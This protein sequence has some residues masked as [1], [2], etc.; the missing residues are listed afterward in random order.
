MRL[1]PVSLQ[2]CNSHLTLGPQ[3]S[4][5]QCHAPVRQNE[6]VLNAH[7]KAFQVQYVP[8]EAPC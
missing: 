8:V 3:Y 1:C 4:V 6:Q 5:E 2:I 7:L